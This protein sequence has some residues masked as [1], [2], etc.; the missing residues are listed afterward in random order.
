M[1]MVAVRIFGVFRARVHVMQCIGGLMHIAHIFTPFIMCVGSPF[2]PIHC[3]ATAIV[4]FF[5]FYALDMRVNEYGNCMCAMPQFFV[6]HFAIWSAFT[7]HAVES[8]IY[9]KNNKWKL[10]TTTTQQEQCNVWEPPPKYT[11]H[12][13]HI[14]LYD[15]LLGA[16]HVKWI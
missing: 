3:T 12:L 13:R 4:F 9:R 10:S 1:F 8:N 7:N 16:E 5:F 11:L 6:K 2:I 15:E 14:W